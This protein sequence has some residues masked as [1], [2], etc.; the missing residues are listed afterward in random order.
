MKRCHDLEIRW[1]EVVW[2]ETKSKKVLRGGFYRPPNS[3]AQYFNKINESIDNAN[4]PDAIILKG[5]SF[6]HSS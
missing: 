1:I 3:N 4:I 2:V 5:L 6:Q